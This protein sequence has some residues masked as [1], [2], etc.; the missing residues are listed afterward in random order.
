[1]SEAT[2]RPSAV[3][4][5]TLVCA[6]RLRRRLEGLA[7]DI[8]VL[9]GQ[10]AAVEL[11]SY[12]D[13]PRPT[14]TLVLHGRGCAG[15]GEHVGWTAAAH[16]AFLDACAR[17]VPRGRRTL[18][19]LRE[20]L[21][22]RL[23]HPHD[24]AAVEAAAID[25]AL[26]QQGESLATLSGSTPQP[27]RYVVSFGRCADPMP[28]ALREQAARTGQELKLDVEP[29]WSDATLAAL[30]DL[31]VVAVLDWKTSGDADAHERFHRAFPAALLE[32][33]ALDPQ[34]SSSRSPSLLR[35]VSFDQSLVRAADVDA[36][37]IRPAAVN[38]KPARMGGVL[39][40]LEAIARASRQGIEVYFGGMF[41][42]GV[43]RTQLLSLASLFSPAA[44]NDI[45]PIARTDAPAPRPWRLLPAA[46]EIPGFG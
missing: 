31:G 5:H 3:Q 23:G 13:G 19:A 36:F 17:A 45:A 2:R 16:A 4:E 40:A 37:P 15:R 12:P 28:E 42:V 21:R 14:S 11:P 32:D 46:P 34:Q 43:G 39:E 41:E 9:D 8:E 18:G 6:D 30:A 29:T 26:R 44:P 20:A 1:M 7:V 27:V 35:H 25:L 38:I 33:P 24:R 22:E 10:P